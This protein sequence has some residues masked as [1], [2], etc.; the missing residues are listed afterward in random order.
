MKNSLIPKLN[1]MNAR[2]FFTIL[3]LL[4]GLSNSCRKATDYHPVLYFTDTEQFPE[5]RLTVDGPTSVGISVTS[6][7]KV[8]HDIT[9]KIAIHPELVQTYNQTNGTAYEFLPDGS[10]ELTSVDNS[11]QIKTGT[12]RSESADFSIL[13]LAQFEEG[14]TYCVPISITDVNGGIP[15]LES[16]RTIYLIIKRTIITQAASLASNRYFTVPGFATDATLNNLSN[17][18]LECRVNVNAFQTA[19]PF[20]SSIIG[21]EEN[22]LLRFGDV[23]IANNQLQLAG[24]LVNG[25]KFPVTSKGSFSTGQWIHVAVVYNGATMALYVNGVLDNYADAESG[26]INLTDSY[27][28]G[29]H[30]GFSAGGRYL[31]GAISEA[32]VWKKALTPNELQNN[33]CFVD[34][35]SK[36]LVAY[37][38]FNGTITGNEVPDLTGHGYTAVA[39]NTITWIPGV[40][41]P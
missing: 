37:W 38:R 27:S 1:K 6:S 7:V 15:V 4:A 18:T 10:Y 16:S 25:K 28:G 19:N 3:I 29:F 20:I 30:I 13:S 21:I 14:V 22:F 36:D 2:Y 24:G 33:L 41:C 23:S 26:G 5:K 32:R 34:P 12:N 9:A 17:L 35:T 11:V 39:N 8:D 31:N 40:R